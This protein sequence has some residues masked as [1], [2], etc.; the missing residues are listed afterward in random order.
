MQTNM[1]FAYHIYV[2]YTHR[3]IYLY[4][5]IKLDIS[6]SIQVDISIYKDRYIYILYCFQG[7]L[8]GCKTYIALLF[9][10][11]NNNWIATSDTSAPWK[12]NMA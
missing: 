3:R 2:N 11:K 9:E 1:A 8:P 12:E 4:L 7:M 6:L 10:G 5:S